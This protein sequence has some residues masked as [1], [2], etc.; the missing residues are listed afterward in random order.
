M[1]VYIYTLTPIFLQG[2][3]P[4]SA[5]VVLVATLTAGLAVPA[6]NFMSALASTYGNST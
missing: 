1:D 4:Y 2:S 3:M 5:T 6:N